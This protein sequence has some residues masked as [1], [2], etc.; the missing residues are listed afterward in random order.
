MLPISKFFWLSSQYL[1]NLTL[2]VTLLLPTW[3]QTKSSLTWILVKHPHWSPCFF[4]HS[5]TFS[6]WQLKWPFKNNYQI[7]SLLCSKPSSGSL[8]VPKKSPNSFNGPQGPILPLADSGFF[9]ATWIYQEC[10]HPSTCA[11]LHILPGTPSV[12]VWILWILPLAQTLH[13]SQD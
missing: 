3:V 7:M 9:A 11:L 5:P 4:P 12:A 2:P 10:S 1:Q 6:A 13:K 8:I